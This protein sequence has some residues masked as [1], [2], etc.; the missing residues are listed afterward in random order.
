MNEKEQNRKTNNCRTSHNAEVLCTSLPQLSAYD[1]PIRKHQSSTGTASSSYSSISSTE[2]L[3]RIRNKLEQYATNFEP[4]FAN[5]QERREYQIRTQLLKQEHDYYEKYTHEVV[6]SFDRSM[7]SRNDAVTELHK[8]MNRL[9]Q[10]IYGRYR[11]E[12]VKQDI[13]A[14]LERRDKFGNTT[15]P[16]WHVLIYLPEREGMNELTSSRAEKSWK[17]GGVWVRD[18]ENDPIY[19]AYSY[20][21]KYLKKDPQAYHHI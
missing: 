3:R 4:I 1:S 9:H 10:W 14:V 15:H 21:H 18:T 6:L 13:Y 11:G 8:A 16:H 19:D 12:H 5:E 20:I 17:H 2:S 7:I